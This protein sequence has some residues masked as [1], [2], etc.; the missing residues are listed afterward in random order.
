LAAISANL[1]RCVPTAAAATEADNHKNGKN[2]AKK[3]ARKEAGN[4]SDGGELFTM[5]FG[6]KDL[7]RIL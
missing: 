2:D 6:C 1:P 5:T 7:S 3:K 4:D